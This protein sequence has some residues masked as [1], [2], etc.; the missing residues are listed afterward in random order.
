ML[1][2]MEGEWRWWMVDE[3]YIPPL[4]LV[5]HLPHMIARLIHRIPGGRWSFWRRDISSLRKGGGEENRRSVK[6]G[7]LQLTRSSM[8]G[9]LKEA[10]VR[11][12]GSD[13]A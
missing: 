1:T 6:N 7:L 12:G 3:G 8:V 10:G 9:D 4:G 5:G 13:L 2:L 11:A